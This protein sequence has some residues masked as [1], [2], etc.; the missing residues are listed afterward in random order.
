M[1]FFHYVFFLSS[2]PPKG[3]KLANQTSSWKGAIPKKFCNHGHFFRLSRDSHVLRKKIVLW[4][5][6]SRKQSLK[7]IGKKRVKLIK[8][9]I[10]SH[11]RIV[12]CKGWCKQWN[13]IKPKTLR[14]WLHDRQITPKG[15]ISRT[16]KGQ[17][18]QIYLIKV[19]T[20]QWF[21][22]KTPWCFYQREAL[23]QGKVWF[24]QKGTFVKKGNFCFLVYGYFIIL[25]SM[26]TVKHVFL[27]SIPLNFAAGS[28]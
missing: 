2:R 13:I 6:V 8:K 24:F 1:I 18:D 9:S 4:Y 15:A 10:K 23:G 3:G 22:Q 19:S 7:V 27:F 11:P 26:G 28:L 25:T 12:N 5:K 20:L 17:I 16:R 14:T 21:G